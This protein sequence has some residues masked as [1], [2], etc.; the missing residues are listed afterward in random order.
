MARFNTRAAK[1]Q[2]TSRVTST[3]RVLRTHQG[4]RGQERDA[5]SELFLLAIANF[6]SQNTFYE[7]GE[8]RD[9]RF[10]VLVRELAVADPRG[11][12]PCWA[13]CAARATCGRP[14]SWAP[15]ST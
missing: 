12:P 4:G 5:R 1:A 8:A 14:R 3:G 9:D 10:A 15:P 7:T 11:R 6:V 13:G 2:P